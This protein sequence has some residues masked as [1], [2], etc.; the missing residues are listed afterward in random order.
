MQ[1][2]YVILVSILHML[3]P[4]ILGHFCLYRPRIFCGLSAL[5]LVY[6]SRRHELIAM[7]GI[8]DLGVVAEYVYIKNFF[9]DYHGRLWGSDVYLGQS[10]ER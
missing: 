1:D 2:R 6:G 10:L 8:S 3:V 9:T 7:I 5:Q 4:T